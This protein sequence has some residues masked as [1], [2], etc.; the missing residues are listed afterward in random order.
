R[1]SHGANA[2]ICPAHARTSGLE[3]GGPALRTA[4]PRAHRTLSLLRHRRRA[5]AR[6]LGT[7]TREESEV[8]PDSA[9]SGRRRPI[10]R[11][12][13]A[14]AATG[15]AGPSGAAQPPPPAQILPD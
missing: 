10:A 3:P 5:I 11:R 8:H 9:A 6:R 7:A 14:R 15:S 13:R 2:E 1:E 4:A 12:V